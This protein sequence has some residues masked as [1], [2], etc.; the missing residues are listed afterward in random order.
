M[1]PIHWIPLGYQQVTLT[2]TAAGLTVP[3]GATMGMFSVETQSARF[4]DDGTAPT[5]SVGIVIPVGIAPFCYT[6]NLSALL[7]IGA[8]SILNVS[9]YKSPG[10]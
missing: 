10:F 6:G 7:L 1:L 9:Y 8:G 2:G 4:R 3:V 5:A